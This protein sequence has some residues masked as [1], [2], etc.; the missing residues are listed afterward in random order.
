MH[1]RFDVLY[2][3]EQEEI[4]QFLATLLESNSVSNSCTNRL[5][6]IKNYCLQTHT[7]ICYFFRDLKYVEHCGF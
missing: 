6:I 2:L 4:V 7:Q 3:Y 5:V 1:F